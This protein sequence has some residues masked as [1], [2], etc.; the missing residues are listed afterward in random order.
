MQWIFFTP[1]FT[2]K[3]TLSGTGIGLYMAKIIVETE[4]QGTLTAANTDSGALL[5]ISLPQMAEK[6]VAHA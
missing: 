2:T 5:T 3:G 4:M 6:D 1:Y